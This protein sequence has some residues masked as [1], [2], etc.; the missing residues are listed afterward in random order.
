MVRGTDPKNI[1]V[2]ISISIDVLNRNLGLS[3]TSHPIDR[4]SVL[5]LF[6]IGL[7]EFRSQAAEYIIASDKMW[8]LIIRHHEMV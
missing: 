3:D 1:G 2:D 6:G 7:L 5:V 4:N 8:V